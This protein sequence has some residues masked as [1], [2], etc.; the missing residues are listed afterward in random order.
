[1]HTTKIVVGT[2]H[3]SGTAKARVTKFCIQVDYLISF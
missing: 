1:M 3:I 2:N